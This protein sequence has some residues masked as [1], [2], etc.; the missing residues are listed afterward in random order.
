M[1]ESKFP[2]GLPSS[3]QLETELIRVRYKERYKKLLKNTIYALLVVAAVSV[4]IATLVMPIL[5]ISGLSMTPTLETGDIVVSLKTNKLQRGDVCSFYYNNHILVKR[6]IG[7]AGDEIFIDEAGTVYVNG[8]A[9]E[10]PYVS[11]KQLGDC[12]I[13]FPYVVPELT[14]FVLGDNRS[15]SADSR[16]MNIG[17]ISLDEVVGKIIFRIWPLRSFGTIE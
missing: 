7:V 5:E 11:Q 17:C 15:N 3:E 10:E 6:V 8:E 2:S 12:D 4:L 13:E 9:L 14:I 1:E 16:N